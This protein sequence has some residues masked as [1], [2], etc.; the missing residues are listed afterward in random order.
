MNIFQRFW[1]SVY[2]LISSKSNFRDMPFAGTALVLFIL[3][4][5]T[6]LTIIGYLKCF[7]IIII[8]SSFTNLSYSRILWT[9]L[10]CAPFPIIYF[11]C[12]KQ[13]LKI[14]E[15]LK[16]ESEVSKKKRRHEV[17]LITLFAVFLLIGALLCRIY[18]E[19]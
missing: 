1:Y 18:L 8:G 19:K 14:I 17:K 10:L 2:E 15:K 16:D 12:K 13:G 6:V 4:E 7:S 3:I 9:I 11:Y 5:V